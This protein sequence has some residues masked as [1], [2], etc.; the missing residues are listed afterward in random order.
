MNEE[1][2]M[3]KMPLALVACLG[4]Q[5]VLRRAYEGPTK[6]YPVGHVGVLTSFQR[7]ASEG[8]RCTVALD[9][10]DPMYWETFQLDEIQ[11]AG[12]Q[13]SFSLDIEGGYLY[14]PPLPK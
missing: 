4:G 7:D 5:V 6:V 14:S 2:I 11:P 3:L 1:S 12:G 10:D 8:L 13:V 9:A